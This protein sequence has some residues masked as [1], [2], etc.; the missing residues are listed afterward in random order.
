MTKK[1]FRSIFIYAAIAVML[2]IT[3]M[4]VLMNRL[5]YETLDDRLRTET[6]VLAHGVERSGAG[7]LSDADLGCVDAVL[8][9]EDGHIIFA[10]NE[11]FTGRRADYPEAKAARREGSGSTSKF[12]FISSQTEINC[13]VRLRDGSVLRTSA[14]P[15]SIMTLY[16]G[17]L[18]SAL[19]LLGTALLTAILLARFISKKIMK[20]INSINLENPKMKRAYPEL[21]PLLKR[22][23]A[24]NSKVKIQMEELRH[25]R[26][27][28]EAIT[29]SM[30]EGLVF[31]SPKF[32]ILS[33]N[34]GALKLL[35]APSGC[36][37]ISVFSLNNTDS[38]RHC[39]QNA[40]GGKRSDCILEING[41][42]RQIIAS[43]S[44]NHSMVNG[45]VIF[46]MDVTEH[47]QL[48]TMRREFTSNVSH[49]LK[50][51]LTTI[52]GI[53]DML[54]NGLVKQEDVQKFGGNIRSESERLITL[55]N[56]IVSLSKLDEGAVPE[57]NEPVDL[58]ALSD[59]I[60][61]RLK[62]AADEKKVSFR[63][64]G[65]H[66]TYVGNRVILDEIVFNLCDNAVK[67]N[68]DGGRV[69][70]KISHIPKYV[71]ITV[72]DTGVGIPEYS[73]N[74][75]F[76]RFYRVDKS[77][78]GKIKGTGLGLSIVKHGVMYHNGDIHAES[79][80]GEGTTFTVKLPVE[81]SSDKA[82]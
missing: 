14:R 41:E 12:S 50:T 7:F 52:Y 16:G 17:F 23:R 63:L 72:S 64:R 45:V 66:V 32:M 42:N 9:S 43:P 47:Q 26:E 4:V 69:D 82:E 59:E 57:E 2:T 20:P 53:S 70:V 55:I 60:I 22:L 19:F 24:Q 31:V 29:E 80:V 79:T 8:I 71:L 33:C 65:D 74:R 10:E 3:I 58:Y 40:A 36:E 67:Y 28:F 61:G 5:G 37:G 35:D 25:S 18:G 39:V 77:R 44:R 49:E 6:N 62:M 46:I 75:I 68:K 54:A 21:K 51:P 15:H 1:I 34:S 11:K 81:K 30:S 48:E 27:Q 78:S 56:D 73:L 76:E 38:F 13:A